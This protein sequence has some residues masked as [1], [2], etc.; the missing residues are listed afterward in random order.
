L[1]RLPWGVF[2]LGKL[3]PEDTDD[4]YITHVRLLQIHINGSPHAILEMF[5]AGHYWPVIYESSQD[6]L[7]DA[8]FDESEHTPFTGALDDVTNARERMAKAVKRA[9]VGMLFTMQHTNNWRTAS[10][11][12]GGRKNE[13]RG[14]A[15]PAHRNII[16]GRPLSVKGF[17]ERIREYCKNG[18]HVPAFQVLVRGHIKR[19]VVGV[20]RTGRKVIWIEP[21]WR[22]PEDAPILARPHLIGE[23]TSA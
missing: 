20:G 14:G 16:I 4:R 5:T 12:S 23:K 19:Q 17:A 18:S 9:V 3:H 2:H 22:G 15:P 21:Y 7:A 1:V 10:H 11:A 8:L 13:S 6:T